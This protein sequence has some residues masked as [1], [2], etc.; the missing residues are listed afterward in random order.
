MIQ[1]EDVHKSYGGQKVLEGITFQVETGQVVTIIG[2]SG[3]GKTVLLRQMMGLEKP[4]AGRILID[5]VNIV[6][7]GPD[8]L[9]R[10][11]RSIGILFQ[12]GA[13]FD[14]LTVFEN[15][16]FPVREHTRMSEKQIRNTVFK[17]LSEVGLTDAADKFPHQIS[18]G[19]R[20]RAGLARA[21]VLDPEIVYFDEPTTGLDP[22]AKASLYSRIR[23]AHLERAVTFVLVSHD[24]K[25]VLEISDTILMLWQGKIMTSGTPD[26]IR[27]HS[28]AL[29][30]QFLTGSAHGPIPLD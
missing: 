4:D 7:I 20:K 3:G 30:Q 8:Q 25:G 5:G 24:I 14:S 27:N 18:G 10:V 12:D 2:R 11:R 15:V 23:Q 9:N 28:H 21:L 22:I 16:A 13:L 17:K 19:M 1:V 29:V 26:Q 6:D